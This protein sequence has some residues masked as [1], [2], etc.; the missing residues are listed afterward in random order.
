HIQ[1]LKISVDSFTNKWQGFLKNVKGFAVG[2]YE[3]IV[4]NSSNHKYASKIFVVDSFFNKETGIYKEFQNAIQ[5][6]KMHLTEKSL[7]HNV[8]LYFRKRGKSV[9]IVY[10]GEEYK[11]Y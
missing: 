9:K 11:I 4:N 6:K 10:E 3:V 5:Q 2:E 8:K 7:E 1:N